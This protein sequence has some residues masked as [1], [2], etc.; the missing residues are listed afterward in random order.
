MFRQ[1]AS[2]DCPSR[3]KIVSQFYVLPALSEKI[4][5]SP[6]SIYELPL[7]RSRYIYSCNRTRLRSGIWRIH[8]IRYAEISA[9]YYGY[10]AHH[11]LRYAFG[12]AHGNA[13]YSAA[14]HRY[15][16]PFAV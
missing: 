7:R 12:A 3:T 5:G 15:D 13:R 14:A 1:I 2:L 6:A 9:A 10:V 8:G 16:L 11:D 4:Y